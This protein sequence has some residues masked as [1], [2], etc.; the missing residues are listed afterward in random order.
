MRL[1]LVTPPAILP[2]SVADAQAF[3][4]VQPEDDVDL[5]TGLVET[6]VDLLDGPSGL[7][8]RAIVAQAWLLELPARQWPVQLVLPLEPVIGV[9][10]RYR[11]LAGD[12]VELDAGHV[13][14]VRAPSRPVL[15]TIR[16][17]DLP[18]LGDAP[19]PV[20]V[21]IIAGFGAGAED[22]PSGIRTAIKMM[23]RHWFDHSGA[24]VV[25]TIA[26]EMPL[27]ASA[28]LARWRL[29]L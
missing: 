16:Q 6:A 29:L 18:A 5:I 12:L 3:C 28:L 26:S 2:V 4:D 15:M 22:V 21:E 10:V 17:Q 14:L 9:T 1:T 23:V 27:S 19:W 11:D 25:G 8:G 13:D 7:L 24:G 20:Q